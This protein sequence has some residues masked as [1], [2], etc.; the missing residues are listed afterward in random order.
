MR[1]TD[2]FQ[3]VKYICNCSVKSQNINSISDNPDSIREV[4]PVLL[5]Y[6]SK[7]FTQWAAEGRL[8]F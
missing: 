8:T 7:G 4:L 1:N 6:Y 3:L 5:F 2:V